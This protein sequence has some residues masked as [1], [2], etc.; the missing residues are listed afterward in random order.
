MTYKLLSLA[1]WELWNSYIKKLPIDQQD[2]YYTPEYYSLYENY[3]DG[4]AQCFVFEKDGEIAIY[5]FLINSINQLGYELDKEYFDIEGAYGYNG[6]VS[7][8]YKPA[9]IYEFYS[10]FD[11]FV[12]ENNIVAEFTRFHPIFNNVKFS[13][14]PLKTFFDRSTV[15]IDTTKSIDVLWSDL[16]RTTKKQINRC[17]NRH[18]VKIKVF[19]GGE[20]ELDTLVNI[21][22]ESMKRVK[23][24]KYLFFNTVYFRQL[25]SLPHAIQY[26]A[27]LDDKPISTIIALKGETILHGHLGGTRNE[28]ISNSP[29]SLLYWEM[30]KTAK[31][32]NLK[33]VHVGGGTNADENDRLLLYKQHFSNLKSEFHIGKKVHNEEIYK[34][35][36]Q[37]WK[38]KHPTSYSLHSNKILGYREIE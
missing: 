27:Y 15:F 36:I 6:V 22:W 17:Y 28:F 19:K 13:E 18:N 33:Y 35:I 37:Q 21:Y 10:A 34:S 5:P 8:S 25:L 24:N 31:E 38:E 20:F 1:D 12:I 9:F 32:Y 3:G 23:S 7:S 29:F 2:I 26:V 11:K 16:Q 30:I 4:K 14:I